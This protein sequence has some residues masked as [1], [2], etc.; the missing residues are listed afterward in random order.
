[1]EYRNPSTHISS[2]KVIASKDGFP[3]GANLFVAVSSF[4]MMKLIR[5]K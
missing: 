4:P 2:S 5:R 3:F 1:M